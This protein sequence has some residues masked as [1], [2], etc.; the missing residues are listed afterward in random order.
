MYCSSLSQNHTSLNDRNIRFP[1]YSPDTSNSF[2]KRF[3]L[4]EQKLPMTLLKT[5]IIDDEWL[6]RFELKRM[7]KHYPNIQV[8]GEADSSAEA[9][10]LFEQFK[11]DLL[12]V[13]IQLP[14]GPCFE[15]LDRVNGQCKLVIITAFDHYLREVKKYKA[16]DY[17]MKPI[18][19]EKLAKVIQKL[20]NGECL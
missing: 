2:K 14:G 12:F 11:P 1:V 9:T 8:I 19:K 5:L 16:I 10:R 13:D 3:Y 15:F 7:L 20:L 17:L 4:T 18:S 6:I